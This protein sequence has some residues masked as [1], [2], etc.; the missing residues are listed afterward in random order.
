MSSFAET[1]TVHIASAGEQFR[2]G[3]WTGGRHTV[4]AD[5]AAV[6]IDIL[7]FAQGFDD[8][9]VLARP[10]DDELR[11]LVQAVIEDLER[12]EHMAPVLALVVQALVEHVHNLVKVL[13]A[14][15]MY[16][17]PLRQ[18]RR[19]RSRPAEGQTLTC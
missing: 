4:L 13:T 3:A 2:R 5:V 10:G 16:Q 18:A 14:A 12:L 17:R 1:R 11:T 7:E 9:K 15:T 8:V 6:L 19:V